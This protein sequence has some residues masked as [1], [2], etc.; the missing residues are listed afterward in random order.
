M[1][2]TSDQ[3]GPD[4]TASVWRQA[5]TAARRCRGALVLPQSAPRKDTTSGSPGGLA[6]SAAPPVVKCLTD[7]AAVL[8]SMARRASV[9]GRH[10]TS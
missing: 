4:A 8:P 10:P 6:S 7:A 2:M 9:G 5:A 1:G 3:V